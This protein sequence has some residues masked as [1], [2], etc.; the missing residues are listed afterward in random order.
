MKKY[1]IYFVN[2]N[3]DG[4]L[5]MEYSMLLLSAVLLA[6]DFALNKLYQARNGTSKKSVLGFNSLL[7][8]FTVAV[9]FIINGFKAD[10]SLYSFFMAGAMS[11]L[12]MCYNIIGFRILRS[13]TMAMYTLFLMTG[14]MTVPYVFGLL[15]LDE[16][17]SVL[18]TV[19]LILL[20]AGVVI[21]NISTEK[22]DKKQIIMCLAVFFIN[23][24]T[25]IISK[26]H[27]TELNYNTVGATDFVLLWGVFRFAI[28]GILYLFAKRTDEEKSKEKSNIFSLV[29]IVLSAL[30]NGISYIMQLL[31]AA[32]LPAT[33]LFPFITGGSII[34]SSLA[35]VIFFKEK[36]SRN[37][38]IS[39]ALCFIGTLT[40][41]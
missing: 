37:L 2:T 16:T 24:C 5:N 39:I 36:L 30:V 21:S 34:A 28:A 29:I 20:L 41:L 6:V 12:V 27:Q 33:V 25:S 11:S 40:F 7:G 17:F 8:L 35:G 38:I 13:G 1:V 19:G 22:P 31:S 3:M 15:F 26:L 9:F 10:F 4:D 14:G 32:T 23:G 18:R